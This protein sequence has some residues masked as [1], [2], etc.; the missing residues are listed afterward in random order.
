MS[1]HFSVTPIY[2][3]KSPY[4]LALIHLIVDCSELLKFFKELNIIFILPIQG[5][6]IKI[7][8]Q[9]QPMNYS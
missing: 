1:L 6:R 5:P 8:F 9:S 2:L 3:G 4:N 7:S